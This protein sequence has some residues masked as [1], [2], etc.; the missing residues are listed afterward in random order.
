[1]YSNV[2]KSKPNTYSNIELKTLMSSSV[3]RTYATE[4]I[5]KNRRNQSSLSWTLNN[6]KPNVTDHTKDSKKVWCAEDYTKSFTYFKRK[7]EI[8]KFQSLGTH[9]SNVKI[10]PYNS[11]SNWKRA[12]PGKRNIQ[13]HEAITKYSNQRSWY[14]GIPPKIQLH[15][16]PK[17]N[18]S[19]LCKPFR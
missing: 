6:F 17:R 11:S 2:K 1:M 12:K 19:P 14:N 9:E 5:I 8:N 13:Y 3:K 16:Y 18:E 4:L 15:L 10:E 7:L